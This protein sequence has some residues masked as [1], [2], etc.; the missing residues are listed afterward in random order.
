MEKTRV[1]EEFERICEV[2]R[3][4]FHNE[5]IVAYAI[6]WAKEHGL[7]YIYDEVN[8][9][10]I[11]RRNA[12]EG[13]EDRP[14]LIL[15]GHLDM[16]AQTDPGVA[17][18]WENDG[19]DYYIDGDCYRARGTT[20]GADDGVAAAIGFTMLSDPDLKNPPLELL[21]TTD[22]EVGMLSVKDA[23][24]SVLQGKYLLNL[25]CGPEGI[26][27]I[28]CA[29][30]TLLKAVVS[31]R[32][33][34]VT[35]DRRVFEISVSGL[36]GG[37]SGMEITKERANAL[38]LAGELLYRLR[39]ETDLRIVSVAADGKDNAISD[40]CLIT[41]AVGNGSEKVQSITEAFAKEQ[42]SSYQLTDPDI[43][44]KLSEGSSGTMLCEETSR[45]LAFLLHTLPYGVQHFD[46][47][48]KKVETSVNLG[49]IEE[50]ESSIGIY[51]SIR[52]QVA[53]R[54]R[55]VCG[56]VRELCGICGAVCEDQDKTYPAWTPVFGSPYVQ[57]VSE[58]FEEMFGKEP[59]CDTTHGGLECGYIMA[60]SNIEAA[61]AIGPDSE[62]E[63]TTA[64]CLSISSLN[65]TCDFV[66]KVIEEL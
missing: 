37:H 6:N 43:S 25:D 52:S 1:M 46:Q 9:N 4:S 26:F 41:A 47:Q 3:Y 27:V 48:L 14:G 59:V 16:V 19:I 13:M 5:K 51:V 60:N 45:T 10:V 35:R 39:A 53:E 57:R 36:R 63:H 24:L 11:I 23:D 54:A 22:E 61:V 20:L 49:L 42:R 21:L 58:I 34:P 56:F 32:Q 7:Q 40:H 15:Q 55:E 66:R 33:E 28:G 18:D 64:E 29:G 44:I 8:G 17:H 62:G 12:A 65:R 30:G 2:P 31:K 38:K 50:D